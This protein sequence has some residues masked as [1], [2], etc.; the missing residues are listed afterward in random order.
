MWLSMCVH[1]H[2]LWH[3]CSRPQGK[4]YDWYLQ[5][6]AAEYDLWPRWAEDKIV[7]PTPLVQLCLFKPRSLS[8]NQCIWNL[9]TIVL[10][11]LEKTIISN[12]SLQPSLWIYEFIYENVFM[13]SWRFCCPDDWSLYFYRCLRDSRSVLTGIRV[14]WILRLSD[15][16]FKLGAGIYY[17]QLT[18]LTVN[19]EPVVC[20]Y[21]LGNVAIDSDCVKCTEL[22]GCFVFEFWCITAKASAGICNTDINNTYVTYAMWMF[23]S[24]LFGGQVY[25]VCW[26]I[27]ALM[28]FRSAV[29]STN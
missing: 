12:A 5:Q 21:C 25:M 15:Y 3:W 28:C 9:S 24:V 23:L 13:L 7:C 22:N 20:E 14:M 18:L 19:W 17:D 26:F 11:L 10:F 8:F 4:L 16:S 2:Q 27:F 6:C 29:V 1:R